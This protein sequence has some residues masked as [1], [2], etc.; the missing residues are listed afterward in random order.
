VPLDLVLIV[1]GI[2]LLTG[3]GDILVAL[4]VAFSLRVHLSRALIGLTIV[5]LGTSAPELFATLFATIDGEADL[6]VGNVVGSNT[7]NIALIL[8]AAALIAPIPV[9]PGLFRLEYPFMVLA[10]WGSFLLFRDGSLDRLEGASLVVALG[11]F[12]SYT[13]YKARRLGV[14][15]PA[16]V[17][18]PKRTERM[19]RWP[20]W[21][22]LVSLA[23]AIVLLAA[24]AAMLIEGAASL[25]LHVGI[26]QRVVGIV[27]VGLGTSL[28]ELVTS[29]MA[30]VR[31]EHEIAVYN[32]VGSNIANLFLVLGSAAVLRP[33]PVAE[34]IVKID[35]WVMVAAALVLFPLMWRQLDISRT[36]G[37]LLLSA[38]LGYVGYLVIFA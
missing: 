13:V 22:L 5:A 23:G 31:R 32:I 27:I 37:G 29:V 33:L 4:A 10:T 16:V 19:S 30:A 18:V 24:G 38:A 36:E 34:G 6:A 9:S 2:L 3:A 26:P 28:P 25:A 7:F 15:P 17:T 35:A 21:V 14:T 11:A 12:M 1:V 20:S 8:G